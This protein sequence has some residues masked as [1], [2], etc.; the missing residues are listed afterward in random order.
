[1]KELHEAL[2][3]Q[4]KKLKEMADT[5]KEVR[6]HIKGQPTEMDFLSVCL[7]INNLLDKNHQTPLSNEILRQWGVTG[8]ESMDDIYKM[9][10]EWMAHVDARG[11]DEV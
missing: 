8:G 1:M 2:E 10:D 3:E 5:L 11:K 6:D 7:T 9:L 4:S